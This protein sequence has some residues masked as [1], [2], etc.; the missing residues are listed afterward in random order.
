MELVAPENLQTILYSTGLFSTFT[1]FGFAEIPDLSV[2]TDPTTIPGFSNYLL[3]TEFITDTVDHSPVSTKN[4][5][6]MA[7]LPAIPY[8][9]SLIPLFA[10]YVDVRDNIFC[11]H[12]L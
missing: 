3:T 4:K 10:F 5:T 7:K 1:G 9:V 12:V 6:A 8:G 11:A 2:N